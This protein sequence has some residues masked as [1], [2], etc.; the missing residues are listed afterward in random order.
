MWEHIEFGKIADFKNGINF[1][2]EQKGDNGIPTI[3]VKNMY[4]DSCYVNTNELYRVNK[5]IDPDY[6]LTKGDLL[7]VRSSLKEEGVGW[8]S[9]FNG[10]SKSVTFCGFIIRARI[11]EESRE[12][13]DTKF[14]TYFFRSDIPRKEL[15]SG[16]GRVAITNINQGLLKSIMIPK[17]SLSEQRK[18]AHV[19]ST[20]QKAIEQ[21]DN[22]MHTTTE[23]G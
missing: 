17:P 5:T 7:F 9:L 3:D 1:E 12:E 20:V 18:I 2:K 14:L 16:S 15:V 19:L 11:K 4:S 10:E 23:L 8:T 6:Y 13:I 21:Q 22:L